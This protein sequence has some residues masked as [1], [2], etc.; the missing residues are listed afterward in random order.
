MKTNHAVLAS[1]GIFL[2]QRIETPNVVLTDVMQKALD[3]GI[4]HVWTNCEFPTFPAVSGKAKLGEWDLLV[5]R[6]GTGL[7]SIT[8]WIEGKAQVQVIFIRRSRWAQSR[9]ENVWGKVCT[10]RQL[11]ETVANLEA[12]LEVPIGPSPGGTGWKLLTRFHPEWVKNAPTVDLMKM[13]LFAGIKG[14]AHDLVFQRPPQGKRYVHKIDRNGD[15]LYANTF[16]LAHGVGNPVYDPG[17][18]KF[19]KKLP[20]VWYCTVYP[21]EE[22]LPDY[23][24]GTYYLATPII[25]LMNHLA[26]EIEFHHGNY[27]PDAH[28]S[29]SKWAKFLWECRQFFPAGSFE[30]QA[31]KQIAI[32]TVGLASYGG[33]EEDEETEKQRPDIKCLTVA[34]SYELMYHSILKF[35]RA[36]GRDPL[37]CYIDAL[38]YESDSP[39]PAFL[40]PLL[41]RSTELG[42]FKHEG[43]IEITPEVADILNHQRIEGGAMLAP[44]NTI[45]WTPWR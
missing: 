29:F 9:D 18:S 15:Y 41:A 36:T 12:K 22:A 11:L 25:N 7:K 13:R 28:Q 39:D 38:Y 33:F 26:Y 14:A 3:H 31:I 30:R 8:G 23:P 40:A 32:G 16:D 35:R 24:Q 27:W 43:Y 20:G 2:P 45:G 17:G 44:L 10:P 37:M 42:G 5:Q 6:K 19:N 21:T 4:T 1:T 34:R